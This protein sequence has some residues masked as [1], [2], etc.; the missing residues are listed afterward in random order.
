MSQTVSPDNTKASAH[1]KPAM[2]LVVDD[3]PVNQKV[4]S[5]VLKS[6]GIAVVA[7]SSGLEALER[8]FK[9]KPDLVLLDVM[10]PD[11]DGYEVCRQ[12]KRHV[13]TRDLPVIFLTVK[14]ETA[15]IVKGF[16]S[17]GTDY[18]LKPFQSLELLARVRTHVELK[19]AREEIKTLRG[20]VP[21][22]ASCSSVRDEAG[23]WQSLEEYVRS[24]TEAEF[25]HGFCPPCL[26]KLYPEVADRVLEKVAR[27]H[28]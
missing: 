4:L 19:R 28:D 7:V 12:L 23:T 25:S 14:A 17:G 3:N 2:V 22:C 16:E 27:D 21:V 24:H 26:R 15:D 10:M 20:I 13:S 1:T 18:V 8:A 9:D 6:A 11:M 5:G